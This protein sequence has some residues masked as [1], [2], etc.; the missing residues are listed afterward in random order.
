MYIRRDFKKLQYKQ[1]E[2]LHKFNLESEI[3][4]LLKKIMVC[5]IKNYI[6]GQVLKVLIPFFKTNILCG[7][8]YKCN[9]NV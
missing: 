4:L 1:G 9:N 6:C 5:I 3:Q 8:F 7:Y 2:M